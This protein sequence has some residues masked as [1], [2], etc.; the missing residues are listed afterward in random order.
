MTVVDSVPIL[1]IPIHN[2]TFDEALERVSQMVER[3]RDTGAAYQIATVNTDFLVNATGDAELHRILQNAD[4][5]YAD[6]M[7]VV[8]ASKLLGHRLP[9]RVAG[10]DFVPALCAQAAAMK[11][12]VMFFGG[13]A[14][15]AA[16][17]AAAMRKAHPGLEI[18][19]AT[20]VVDSDGATA[21]G[22]IGQI[23]AFAPDVLC[24]GLGNPKQERFIDRYATALGVPVSIGIGG[25]FEF[26]AG[27]VARAP[28]VMQRT[29]FEWLYRMARDPRRL[30]RRYAR[31]LAVFVPAIARQ[32]RL[33]R[34]SSRPSGS[35]ASS[36]GTIDL[37]GV[38]RLDRPTAV[39]ISSLTTFARRTG[40][41]VQ[42]IGISEGLAE[43]LADLH[44]D[45][46]IS[47]APISPSTIPPSSESAQ[48]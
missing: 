9:E 21:V 32:W 43:Q 11:H 27:D 37:S 29:G 44:L 42:Y 6:G 48:S 35:L 33:T 23:E 39:R 12:R 10:A 45:T 38:D 26:M 20:A 28:A 47:S 14:D 25:T 31:D 13:T 2:V 30:A 18:E 1:G 16:V 34:R 4:L 17:A 46:I 7:P 41:H 22:E 24:V 36:D 40:N 19:T 15:A 5:C 3:S 8:W